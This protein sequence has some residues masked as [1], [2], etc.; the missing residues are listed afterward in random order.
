MSAAD[1]VRRSPLA[2]LLVALVLALG[3]G[4]AARAGVAAGDGHPV[5]AAVAGAQGPQAILDLHSHPR[6][7]EHRQPGKA[8]GLLSTL[9]IALLLGHLRRSFR[10]R[11]TPPA[12]GRPACGS[13]APPGFSTT[14][15]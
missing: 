3:L 11:T 7:G 8:A 13:R 10:P 4:G 5:V 1:R 6:L 14:P 2:C 12:L 15:A 9:V